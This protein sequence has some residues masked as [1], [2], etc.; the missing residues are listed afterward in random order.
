MNEKTEDIKMS[1]LDIDQQQ[2]VT[3]LCNFR[4]N[5]LLVKIFKMQATSYID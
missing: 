3:N 5:K 4:N 2:M 1:D